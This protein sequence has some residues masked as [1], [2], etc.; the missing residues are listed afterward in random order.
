MAAH[1][2][3]AYDPSNRIIAIK[4]REPWFHSSQFAGVPAVS[5]IQQFAFQH[6]DGVAEAVDG[7][8]VGQFLKIL[9]A[10]GWEDLAGGMQWWSSHGWVLLTAPV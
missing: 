1:K 7:D 8:I 10:E 2:V 5:A 4:L 9:L 3:L 6:D